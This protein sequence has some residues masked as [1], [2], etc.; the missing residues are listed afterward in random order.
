[1]NGNQKEVLH[2][3]STGSIVKTVLVIVACYFL[4]YIRDIV[5]IILTAIVLASAVE[6][7]I[8]WFQK[9]RVPRVIGALFIY[10]ATAAVM[11]SSFYFLLL[12][13]VQESS[14]LLK[15]LPEYGIAVSQVAEVDTAGGANFFQNF[16]EG[17]SLPAVV[18]T[19]N[20]TLVNLSSGFFGTVD[21]IF[22]GIL[23]FLLIIIISFYLGVQEDGV[24][25]FLRIV[26]PIDKE[27]YVIDL[28]NRSK[29]KI[30]LWMQGQ[31][32]LAIIVAVLVYLGLTLIGV[33]NALLLAVLAG[34][35]EIIP[36]F[37]AFLAAAPAVLI[38][39]LDGGV[40]LAVIVAGL[41][42]IIQQFESQL[43]Y[44]VVV[45]KVVGVPPIVSILAL[46]IGAKI[47]GFLGI[48]LSVPI[49]AVLM[50]LLKDVER[51]KARSMR[52]KEE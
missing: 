25:Q 14:D 48:V 39:F 11:V 41:F 32:L 50:E 30:G 7:G 8:K 6:P 13:L 45:K 9:R 38:G 27:A 35:F 34:V 23:S 37:G 52:E 42:L 17:F 44:P 47:A 20:A 5:L 4:Y 18:A 2:G 40:T 33:R 22:G 10:V 12:P 43:I 49:A 15:T 19:V 28:W 26:T 29:V 3:I 21:V 1:M 31:L 46:I 24:G 51:K 16:S 36:L